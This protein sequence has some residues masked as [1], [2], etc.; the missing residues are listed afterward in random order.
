MLEGHWAFL[1]LRL[2]AWAKRRFRMPLLP[3]VATSS[4]TSPRPPFFSSGRFA[5]DSFLTIFK[6]FSYFFE[7]CHFEGKDRVYSCRSNTPENGNFCAVQYRATS[8]PTDV[9]VETYHQIH[10][11]R[12][13][14]TWKCHRYTSLTISIGLLELLSAYSAWRNFHL[15]GTWSVVPMTIKEKIVTEGCPILT[16]SQIVGLAGYRAIP[17]LGAI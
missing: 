11:Y 8:H 15:I 16:N 12:V 13:S 6:D 7:L 3:Q 4:A 1:E 9:Y 10:Q 17:I 5:F 2:P 14:T